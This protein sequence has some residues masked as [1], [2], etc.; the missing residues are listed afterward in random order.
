MIAH[1][2]AFKL[3]ISK[4]SFRV[5]V[6]LATHVLLTNDKSRKPRYF[7]LVASQKILA[8]KKARAH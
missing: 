4:K 5:W 6:L 1:L 3:S 8:N 2:E 7:A